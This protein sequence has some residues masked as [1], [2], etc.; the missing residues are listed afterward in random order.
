MTESTRIASLSLD[1]DNQWSYMKT[2]GNPDWASLPSYLDVVTPRFLEFLDGLGCTITV[3][4][5]GQDA[6]EPR[7]QGVLRS[8]A[9]AGHEIGN[10][11]FRHEPWLHLYTE[12]GIESEIASAEVAIEQATGVRPCG[13][14]GPGYSLSQN[15]LKVL[16]RRRYAYDASTLPTFIGPLARTYYFMSARLTPEQRAERKKL[17]GSFRDGLR[18][19]KPYAWRIDEGSLLEI[20]VTT[21]PV[22]R[23]PIHLS[24]ILYL[25]M[26]SETLALA[27]FRSAVFACR[28]AGIE[29]SLLLHPL[30]F[31]G[32]GEAPPLDFFP[33][34]RVAAST[35]IDV[36]NRALRVFTRDF[37]VVSLRDHARAI[38]GRRSA[39]CA[40]QRWETS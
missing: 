25:A 9:R 22:L 31:L 17:F 1:L 37:R 7:H 35:K 23:T 4:V 29:P 24:Y 21:M 12:Q 10:H 14:R 40:E 36:L 28:H 8:I 20:P 13:F 34:M 26:Y 16:T 30:D 38:H 32:R 11:S 15:V 27:Y 19:L 39:V 3:F 5:V 18:P 6:A 33:A 2:H